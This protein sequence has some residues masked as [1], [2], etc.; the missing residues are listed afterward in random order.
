MEQLLIYAALFCLNYG[1]RPGDISFEL[2]IYQNNE[3][4]VCN[5]TEEDISPIMDKIIYFDRIIQEAK[6]GSDNVSR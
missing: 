5:P 4:S 3:I 1:I 6:E 2:R